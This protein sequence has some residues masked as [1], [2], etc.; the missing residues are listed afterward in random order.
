MKG[1]DREAIQQPSWGGL[2]LTP[3][4][5][6]NTQPWGGGRALM[7]RPGVLPCDPPNVFQREWGVAGGP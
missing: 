3:P 6:A 1:R 7:A 5:I 4:L 2:P